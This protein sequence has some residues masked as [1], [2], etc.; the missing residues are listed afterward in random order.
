MLMEQAV[1]TLGLLDA[2]VVNHRRHRWPLLLQ[3][4]GSITGQ[5]I[6]A[7]GGFRRG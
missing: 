7:E 1:S 6:D 3:D 5:V 2:L 4:A